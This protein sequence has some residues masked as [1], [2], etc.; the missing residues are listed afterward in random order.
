MAK[1]KKKTTKKGLG[2]TVAA[3]TKATGIKD[4]VG[5]CEGCNKRQEK[6]NKLFL[7]KEI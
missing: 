3:I 2:D 4:L 7:T 1:R 6:L 5:E